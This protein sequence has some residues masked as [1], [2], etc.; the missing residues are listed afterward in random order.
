LI[1]GNSSLQLLLRETGNIPKSSKPLVISR[2]LK[3]SLAR[4]SQGKEFMVCIRRRYSFT[5]AAERILACVVSTMLR[6]Q[7]K[8]VHLIQPFS[9]IEVPSWFQSILLFMA[10]MRFRGPTS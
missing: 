2:Q 1:L 3:I 8:E 4:A 10:L 7:G 6:G 5:T 9:I